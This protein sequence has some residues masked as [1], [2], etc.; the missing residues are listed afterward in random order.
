M[1]DWGC[2]S[3]KLQPSLDSAVHILRSHS[4]YGNSVVPLPRPEGFVLRHGHLRIV[5][6][7]YLSE[8]RIVIYA[9]GCW[10]IN[11]LAKV[12]RYFDQRKA[13][14]LLAKKKLYIRRL[15]CLT[16]RFEGDPYEGTPTFQM[17]EVYKRF[18]RQYVGPADD[19]E[20]IKRFEYE[21]RATF[22]SCWQKSENESWLM[23]KQYCQSGG[24]FAVQTT[25]R[26]LNHRSE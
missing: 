13:V 5:Y 2:F 17:L 11:P 21:R 23:W 16:D 10:A 15:D 1:A 19:A 22:V 12:W 3:R 26:R 9:I 24:G 18:Y 8:N 14:D 6:R 25:E 20:L 4:G 7:R